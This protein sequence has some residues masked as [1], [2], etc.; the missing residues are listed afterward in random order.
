MERPEHAAGEA[1]CPKCGRSLAVVPPNAAL[2]PREDSPEIKEAVASPAELDESVDLLATVQD[3]P[4]ESFWEGLRR[5][6]LYPFTPSGVGTLIAGTLLLY[7]LDFLILLPA[8]GW[9]AAILL[10]SWLCAYWMDVVAASAVGVATVPDWADLAHFYDDVLK[11]SWRFVVTVVISLLPAGCGFWLESRCGRV[12]VQLWG[13]RVGLLTWC[14][15]GVGMLS[16]PMALCKVSVYRSLAG[17]KPVPILRAMFQFPGQYYL[18]ATA[19]FAGASLVVAGLAAAGTGMCAAFGG[20]PWW[21][22]LLAAQAPGFYILL[23]SGRVLGLFYW[24]N[25]EGLERPVGKEALS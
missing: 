17:A 6:P 3:E 22:A 16:L 12:S 13:A 7:L 20:G 2:A 18:A 4:T 21:L 14:L 8:F 9:V 19:F 5:V 23:L 25:R 24:C 15:A 11:P 10:M 1:T